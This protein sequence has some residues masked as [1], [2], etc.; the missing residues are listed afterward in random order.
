MMA[1]A[2]NHDGLAAADLTPRPETLTGLG[3]V[4]AMGDGRLPR[5]PMTHLMPFDVEEVTQGEITLR[6]RPEERFLNAMASVHGGWSMTM[7]DTAMALAALTTAKVG[8]ICPTHE[9]SVKFV[10]PI[11]L[12]GGALKI[13][14]KVIARGRTL[15]TLEGRIEDGD[16][17]LYA[18]GASSCMIIAARAA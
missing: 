1:A 5:P 11:T 16:G 7:L 2:P 10:R 18:H 14:G 3:I 4:Q 17:K 15:I 12:D 8:E 6:A 13:T 9:T